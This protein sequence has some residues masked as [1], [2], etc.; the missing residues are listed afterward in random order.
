MGLHDY[1]LLFIC[2]FAYVFLLG[3]NSKNVQHSRYVMAFMV[4]WG[5]TISNYF[6]V[7]YAANEGGVE[8]ILVSGLGGSLGIVSAIYIHDLTMKKTTKVAT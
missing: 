1:L 6:F 2:T 3:F 7:I 5:I 4:S 8:F